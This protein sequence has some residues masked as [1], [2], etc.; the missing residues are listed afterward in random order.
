MIFCDIYVINLWYKE[1]ILVKIIK[2][3]EGYNLY[4]LYLYV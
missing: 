2:I 1:I 3:K 4:V